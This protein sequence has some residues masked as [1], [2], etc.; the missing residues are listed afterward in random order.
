MTFWATLWYAGAV[1]V[2]MGYE[3]QTEQ[4]CKTITSRMQADVVA[5]YADAETLADI[6]ALGIFPT[7]QF[8]VSCENV[9]LPVDEKYAK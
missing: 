3:G 4:E 5:S 7:N 9:Q 6:T 2:S 8:T 1:V